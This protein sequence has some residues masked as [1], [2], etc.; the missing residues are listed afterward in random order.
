MIVKIINA[1][2][3]LFAFYM[4]ARQGW[5]MVSGKPAMLQLFGAWGFNRTGVTLVGMVTLM[6]ALLLLFP[7]T[8]VWGNFL[9]AASILLIVC[10]EVSTQN[11]KGAVTELP[12]FILNLVILYFQYPLKK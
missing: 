11:L 1:L 3:V 10:F 5:A 2:F 8:F 7:G 9:M 12:F 6:G 4:G